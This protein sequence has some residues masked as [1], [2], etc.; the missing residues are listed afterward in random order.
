MTRQYHLHLMHGRC[1]LWKTWFG[2]GKTD[3]TEAVVTSPGWAVLFYRWQFLGEGLSLGEMRDT[4]FTLSGVIVWVGK[5]AQRNAKPIS[6]GEGRQLIARPSPKDT[7]NQGGLAALI[8]F[9][10]HQHHLVSIIKICPHNQPTSWWLLND[11]RCPSLGLGQDSRNEVGHHSEVRTEAKDNGSYGWLHPSHLCSH[12][13]MDLRVIGAQHQLHHQC[14]QCL[15]GWE[16]P[17]IH[18]VADIP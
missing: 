11:G 3:L 12:Q 6:L 18:I 8:P 16:D 5:H 7:S 15:W 17:G 2:K 1:W 14:H 4:A 13:T 10:P 9:H